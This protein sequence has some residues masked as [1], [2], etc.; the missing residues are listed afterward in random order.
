MID[1][2]NFT[3]LNIAT[4]N[5]STILK[6][7]NPDGTISD[8]A[9][10]ED[11][12]KVIEK[13]EEY[14]KKKDTNVINISSN[15][16]NFS[17]P[18]LKEEKKEVKKSNQGRKKMEKK[19]TNRKIHGNGTSMS[20]QTSFQIL[21][22]YQIKIKYCHNYE[23]YRT[24][25]LISEDNRI[26][27]VSK[28]VSVKVFRNGN[29]QIQGSETHQLIDVIPAIDE[30]SKCF[31]FILGKK[32]IY[33]D[34]SSTMRN[35]TFNILNGYLINIIQTQLFF[36]NYIKARIPI[37]FSKL[38]LYFLNKDNI[39]ENNLDDI[40]LNNNIDD[41]INEFDFNTDIILSTKEYLY[42]VIDSIK[43]NEIYQEF[44]TFK[45]NNKNVFSENVLNKIK[46]HYLNPF[47]E[48]MRYKLYHS[49]DNRISF[50]NGDFEKYSGLKIKFRSPTKDKPDKETT[51]KIFNSGKIEINGAQ[52]NQEAERVYA[53]LI[54]F[55]RTNIN[56]IYRENTDMP[57]IGW[58]SD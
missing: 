2:I 36:T 53:Y 39:N 47:I 13:L 56:L 16:C 3:P 55:F 34:V 35:Y 46:Y 50:V 37:N 17:N 32:I 18:Q 1:H 41:D 48:E 25:K 21:S 57:D 33:N 20:S 29:I 22:T 49:K 15:F 10:K 11:D 19:K 23:K 4:Q 40:I 51:V 26:L 27:E 24:Y 6:I 31:S 28:S 7:E 45:N 42:N 52:T 43:F 14:I 12:P 30:V 58:D 9:Y 8:M 54:K 38:K 5:V 44:N